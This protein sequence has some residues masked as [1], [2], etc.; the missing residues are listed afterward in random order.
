MPDLRKV[1]VDWDDENRPVITVT[2]A[3]GETAGT[4]TDV[5][6]WLT[7]L[8]AQVSDN[9]AQYLTEML[10]AN[11]AREHISIQDLATEIGIEKKVVDGWNR[12]LGRSVKKVV[13]EVG[14]LRAD[15]EDGTAQ[16][17]DFV[18]DDPNNQWL[19]AVPA[20]FRETLKTGLENR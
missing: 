4:E 16:L 10:K 3:D 15:A 13:R 20:R 2:Y 6:V 1:T 14:F 9:G 5:D 17:F 11:D 8:A 7:A 19:Y 12:N 18:W